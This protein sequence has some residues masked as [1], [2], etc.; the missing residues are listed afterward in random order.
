MDTARTEENTFEFKPCQIL[1]TCLDVSIAAMGIIVSFGQ[2]LK[3]G[4]IS[5]PLS[6][7]KLAFM[8]CSNLL[9]TGKWMWLC[10]L[11]EL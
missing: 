2:L 8:C 10:H 1:P 5:K 3:Y 7:K 6:A 9:K 11:F 4:D